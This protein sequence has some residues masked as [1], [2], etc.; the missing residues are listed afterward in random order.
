MRERLKAILYGLRMAAISGV[1][2]FVAVS[3]F[4]CE[5]E[6]STRPESCGAG[7]FQIDAKSGVCRRLS[8]SAVVDKECCN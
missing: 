8:D 2:V 4:G 5:P 3:H 7:P 6:E 1:L